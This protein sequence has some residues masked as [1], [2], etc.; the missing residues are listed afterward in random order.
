VPEKNGP[1]EGAREAWAMIKRRYTE[2]DT[3]N[4]AEVGP[5]GPN[6]KEV[7]T[8]LVYEN[9]M[10]ATRLSQR[11]CTLNSLINGLE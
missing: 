2:L 4:L 6:G 7:P 8:S 11:D 10:P 5:S 1:C 9:V 3:E